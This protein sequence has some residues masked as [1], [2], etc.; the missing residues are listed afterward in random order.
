[1]LRL[2]FIVFISLVYSSAISNDHDIDGM[3]KKLADF[4]EYAKTIGYEEGSL[5]IFYE[6]K[7][8]KKIDNK[9]RVWF[10]KPDPNS[11]KK[12]YKGY[13]EFDC[14]DSMTLLALTVYDSYMMIGGREINVTKEIDYL[15]SSSG[16]YYFAEKI[17]TI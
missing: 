1:M 7:T 4:R 9:R 16:F 10:I 15:D 17:C 13:A 5:E 12:L 2:F 6:P 3:L 8:L 14:I 11:A